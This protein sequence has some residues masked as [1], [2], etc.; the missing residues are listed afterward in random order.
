MSD[1]DFAKSTAT[2]STEYT[3]CV[4]VARKKRGVA[5]RDGRNRAAG[6]L[7][8][9]NNEWQAFINGVKKGEFEP[10]GPVA[11]RLRR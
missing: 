6:T 11:K 7:F 3:W 8:F 1:A 5:V 9:T 10:I 4:E 2:T